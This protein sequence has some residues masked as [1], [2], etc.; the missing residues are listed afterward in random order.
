MIVIEIHCNDCK[1]VGAKDHR[2]T[3][4]MLRNYLREKGWHVLNSAIDLCPKCRRVRKKKSDRAAAQK[5]DSGRA[6]HSRHH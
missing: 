2:R 4:T 1:V 5:N 3:A 6:L